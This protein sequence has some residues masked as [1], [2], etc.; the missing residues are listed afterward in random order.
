MIHSVLSASATP[1]LLI[2]L[3]SI[4]ISACVALP[5]I[6]G[7]LR[8]KPEAVE[9]RLHDRI[10]ELKSDLD[11]CN[12]RKKELEEENLLLLQRIVRLKNGDS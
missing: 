12:R 4:I 8:Q 2:A 9:K 7:L 5:T 6:L 1:P 11:F 10:K 3:A